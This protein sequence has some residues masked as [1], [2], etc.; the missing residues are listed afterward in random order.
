MSNDVIRLDEGEAKAI[1]RMNSVE[2]QAYAEKKSAA[3]LEMI[4]ESSR[5]VAEAKAEAEAAKSMKS[6]GFFG[7]KTKKKADATA[8]A[9]MKT[10][11]AVAEL[12][13][14]Q[15]EAIHFTCISAEFARV[16]HQTMAKMM[17]S[18][19]R[20][21]HG[22]IQTVDSNAQE[23][24][25]H[26][27]DEAEAFTKN[28]K[29]VEERQAA[30][31]KKL[32]AFSKNQKAVAERQAVQDRTIQDIS[33]IVRDNQRRLQ[34]KDDVDA[35][36]QRGIDK[37]K[38]NITANRALIEENRS[39]NQEQDKELQMQ[40]AKDDEHDALIAR[41]Y[42]EAKVHKEQISKLETALASTS[43]SKAI[44]IVAFGISVLS[45]VVSILVASGAFHRGL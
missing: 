16:M 20:D 15:R 36:Q 38:A 25:Q 19:F 4:N 44:A 27:L 32:D 9:L 8:A 31:D 43:T 23:F 34:K 5:K 40:A 30:Q 17:A 37:N 13:Q 45:L 24:A 33:Q 18:G 42:Q 35:A 2:L 41:L 39:T 22:C 7:G 28:Q 6:G 3:I 26:I 14:L 12:V 29:A 1:Q 11:M 10:N 21:A